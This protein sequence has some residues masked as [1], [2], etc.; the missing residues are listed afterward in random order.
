MDINCTLLCTHQK[1]GK[2]WLDEVDSALTITSD[3]SETGCPYFNQYQQK[4]K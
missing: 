4:Q 2:C 1:D 3:D